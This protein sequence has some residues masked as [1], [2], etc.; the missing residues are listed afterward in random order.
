MHVSVTPLGGPASAAQSAARDVVQYL[1][2]NE[3][4]PGG[5]R[6]E[7]EPELA[8]STAPGSY[9]ADSAEKAGCWYGR[10][11]SEMIPEGQRA[12]VDPDMLE[13]VLLGQHP[14]T[15]E[16]LVGAGGSSGRAEHNHHV[17]V[18][19]LGP[20]DELLTVPQ[21]ARLVDVDPSYIRRLLNRTAAVDAKTAVD[22]QAYRHA[23]L[24]WGARRS[25]VSGR[26]GATKPNASKRNA[27]NRRWCLA[28]T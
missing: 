24:C 17:Q 18:N 5:R 4:R 7:A 11:A 16:Q 8:R 1:T 19:A 3:S 23:R 9:Y 13:R 12:S 6:A 20:P 15:G 28:M 26:S 14:L 21:V 10:G 25:A 22:D 27:K 2:G